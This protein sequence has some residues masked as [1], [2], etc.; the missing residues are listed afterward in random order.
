MTKEI[1]IL[2]GDEECRAELL[3][4]DG[5]PRPWQKHLDSGFAALTDQPDLVLRI[6]GR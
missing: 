6:L 1:R 2:I 5:D 3:V 4:E